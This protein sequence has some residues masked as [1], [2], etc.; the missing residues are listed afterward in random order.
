MAVPAQP[1]DA[2]FRALVDEPARADLLIREYLP[3]DIAALLADE[4]VRAVEGSFIDPG[5]LAAS[6]SDRLFEAR[7][8][9]GRGVLLYVV[10]EHKSRADP[11]TA[12]QMMGYMHRIWQQYAGGAAGR[13]RALPPIIP[14]VFYHGRSPWGWRVRWWRWSTPRGTG[15]VRAVVVVRAVRFGDGGARGAVA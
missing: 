2:L 14:L 7:L 10:L 9:D 11:D 15:S 8:E 5:T 13:L 4:P 6:R 3:P 12:L 1:H